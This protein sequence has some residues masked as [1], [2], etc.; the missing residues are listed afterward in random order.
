M[1]NIIIVEDNGA[2]RESLIDIMAAEGHAVEGFDSAEAFWSGGNIETVDIL[3]L[4][5]N[6]PGE[7]GISIAHR[8]RAD[9]PGVGIVMLTARDA[10][11][12]RRIGY[13]S[14]ADIYLTKPS[15]PPELTS[16]VEA[17]AR[18]L[19]QFRPEPKTLILD[20]STMTL[21]G[22]TNRVA[23]SAAEV[24]I[25]AEF[26]RAPDHRLEISRI[27]SLIG[28]NTELSKAAI[29]VRIVRLRKKL[30]AA[31]ISGQPIK[32]IRN[33]GYQIL[34]RIDVV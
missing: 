29:E 3:I 27:A 14:G 21:S 6:L 20:C 34:H 28:G 23:L 22:P 5:L 4:D 15:S 31:G 13:E 10:P 9:H 1:L 32:A 33:H 7:D 11:D 26:S 18:R 30:M 25:L 24:E 19:K 17:L 12:E 2:L 8:A 16:S